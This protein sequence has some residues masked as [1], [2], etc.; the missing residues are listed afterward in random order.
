MKRN[1]NIDFEFFNLS[2]E[3]NNSLVILKAKCNKAYLETIKYKIK[4]HE[5]FGRCYDVEILE[6]L[7]I[8][9]GVEYEILEPINISI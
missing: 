7:L 6:E 8:N 9:D 1:N 3:D 4:E 2:M 5:L